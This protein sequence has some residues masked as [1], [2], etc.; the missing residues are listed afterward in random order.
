MS[1]RVLLVTSRVFTREVL[2]GPLEE[3]GYEMLLAEDVWEAVPACGEK[4][5][6]LLL[7]DW[8]CPG[9]GGWN[10]WELIKG[11]LAARP[12]LPTI[13]ITGRL[14]LVEA[15]RAAGARGLAEQPVDVRALVELADGLMEQ[16]VGLGGRSNVPLLHQ[17]EQIPA[18]G[19][20]LR[21]AIDERLHTPLLASD[22]YRHWGLND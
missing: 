2:I 19:E 6:D 14:D 3:H 8:D 15:A 7:M 16:R 4:W 1:K 22:A 11:L 21:S 18:D 5:L 10:C 13:I 9:D 17:F 12:G 20:A